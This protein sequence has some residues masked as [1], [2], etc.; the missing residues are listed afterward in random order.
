MKRSR[1]TATC[2]V[3]VCEL[4]NDYRS[5][6]G[7]SRNTGL[8]ANQTRCCLCFL[9]LFATANID[10]WSVCSV[11][12]KVVWVVRRLVCVQRVFDKLRAACELVSRNSSF[13]RLVTRLLQTRR[14]LTT[15]Q[16]IRVRFWSGVGTAVLYSYCTRTVALYYYLYGTSI[17]TCTVL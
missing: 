11:T 4:R 10:I 8:V 13:P 14:L 15:R 16:A 3:I 7:L 9:L 5:P 6:V 2:L 17:R 12:E 1:V